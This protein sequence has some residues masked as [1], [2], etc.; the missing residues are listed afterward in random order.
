LPSMICSC[1]SHRKI[2]DHK[3]KFAKYMGRHYWEIERHEELLEM[4]AKK[5]GFKTLTEA[6][7]FA[8]PFRPERAAK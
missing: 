5:V 4:R 8:R 2:H 6:K 1:G 7:R 3:N